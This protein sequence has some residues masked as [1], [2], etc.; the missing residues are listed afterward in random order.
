[1]P[2]LQVQSHQVP[3]YPTNMWSMP[4]G[5]VALLLLA[6]PAASN[7]WDYCGHWACPTDWCF[8]CPEDRCD[9]MGASRKKLASGTPAGRPAFDVF[10]EG[11]RRV[12]PPMSQAGTRF[13]VAEPWFGN[14]PD[15]RK[16]TLPVQFNT[17]GDQNMKRHTFSSF[18][19][20]TNFPLYSPFDESKRSQARG[21]PPETHTRFTHLS[22]SHSSRASVP[23]RSPH[24][25]C[26]RPT[27]RRPPA[28]TPVSGCGGGLVGPHP[29]SGAHR[30]MTS[31]GMHALTN[32]LSSSTPSCRR[33]PCAHILRPNLGQHDPAMTQP[34]H[35]TPHT[36]IPH[37]CTLGHPTHTHHAPITHQTRTKHT[38]NTHPT[39][40][41]HPHHAP[42]THPTRTQHTPNT[43][44]T[45]TQHTPDTHLARTQ[46]APSTR[47]ARTLSRLWL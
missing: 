27:C 30:L 7:C 44:P 31:R 32:S 40:T 5:A 22:T 43:H 16:P 15:V 24:Y 2:R 37:P 29:T 46:H 25:V 39:H 14:G 45:H 28:P 6:T 10:S 34:A 20:G 23:T 18:L 36:C 33:R 35:D 26:V 19:L 38:P 9:R 12:P 17:S 3:A 1:M 21:S 11:R 42:N 4:I 8:G 47:P 13:P 41:E